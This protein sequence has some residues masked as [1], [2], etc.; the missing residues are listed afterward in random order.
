MLKI[1]AGDF[2]YNFSYYFSLKRAKKY[3]KTSSK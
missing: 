1:D 2:S 3:G